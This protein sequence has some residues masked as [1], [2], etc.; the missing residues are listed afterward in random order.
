MFVLAAKSQRSAKLGNQC[1]R[2]DAPPTRIVN[3]LSAR[4]FPVLNAIQGDVLYY[5]AAPN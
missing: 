4:E 3:P 1:V 2:R 5:D